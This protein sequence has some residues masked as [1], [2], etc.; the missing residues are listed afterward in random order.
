MTEY[1]MYEP[2]HEAALKE[3]AEHIELYEATLQSVVDSS[4]Y[5]SNNNEKMLNFLNCW[6]EQFSSFC[7][8]Y[9]VSMHIMDHDCD[10]VPRFLND[11]TKAVDGNIK[12]YVNEL[13]NNSDIGEL[14]NPFNGSAHNR[15]LVKKILKEENED[16]N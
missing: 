14:K 6:I 9:L 7:G 8:R 12:Y 4:S 2:E 11:I 16:G 3:M 13:C 5:G 10:E 1:R 15:E